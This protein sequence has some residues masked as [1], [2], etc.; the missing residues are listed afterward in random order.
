MKKY[1]LIVAIGSFLC[2]PHTGAMQKKL[3]PTNISDKEATELRQAVVDYKKNRSRVNAEQII[4][5]YASKYPNDSLVKSKISEKAKF[6]ASEGIKPSIV[7]TKP[8]MPQ[9]QQTINQIKQLEARNAQTTAQFMQM[10]QEIAEGE[11]DLSIVNPQ[12]I[13]ELTTKVQQEIIPAMKA[14]RANPQLIQQLETAAQG[15]IATIQLNIDNKSKPAPVITQKDQPKVTKEEL[16]AEKARISKEVDEM[17]AGAKAR[18]EIGTPESNARLKAQI[19]EAKARGEI[20]TPESKAR[21]R[22][23]IAA[24]KARGDMSQSS[25]ELLEQQY[26]ENILKRRAQQ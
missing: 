13:L 10:L 20:G 16:E 2:V 24:A 5:K 21:L 19:A 14:T 8:A 12:P 23:E 17:M 22:A 6:D 9:N 3:T 11:I 1:T 25:K 18:G 4:N 7:V 15:L 26:T